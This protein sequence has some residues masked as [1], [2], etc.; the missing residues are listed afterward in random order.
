MASLCSGPF[1]PRDQRL[2][3]YSS[4]SKQVPGCVCVRNNLG[5]ESRR[6]WVSVLGLAWKKGK[7]WCVWKTIRQRSIASELP[8]I[9]FS[10]TMDAENIRNCSL[11]LR[12]KLGI[13]ARNLFLFL[14]LPSQFNTH[15]ANLVAQMV[16]NLPAVRETWVGR[17]PWRSM[18][19]HSSILA[20]RIPMDSGAWQATVHGVAK[21]QTQLSD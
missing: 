11:E 6:V 16:K 4:N 15:Y 12:K 20:W 17:I 8:E 13:G 18:A 10:R 14:H 2:T 1:V 5:A 19:T 9:R 3:A 7:E 21:S